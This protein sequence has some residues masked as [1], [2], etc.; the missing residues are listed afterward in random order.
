MDDRMTGLLPPSIG[1]LSQLRTFKADYNQL[2]GTVMQRFCPFCCYL[3]ISCCYLDL[4]DGQN[5]VAV[6]EGIARLKR[7]FL[8]LAVVRVRP[9]DHLHHI[10]DPIS[11]PT[12]TQVPNT[13]G[14]LRA[15]TYLVLS[16]NQFTGKASQIHTTRI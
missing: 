3:D 10:R 9:L 14:G 2:Q 6:S 1:S 8:H 15:L 13:I 16:Y 11:L 5:G 7:V 4:F 12:T